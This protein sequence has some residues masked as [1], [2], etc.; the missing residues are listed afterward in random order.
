M[1][2]SSDSP[3]SDAAASDSSP[4]TQAIEEHGRL[5]R[6][7]SKLLG[8]AFYLESDEISFLTSAETVAVSMRRAKEELKTINIRASWFLPLCHWLAQRVN[9]LVDEYPSKSW[10]VDPAQ[11]E[12]DCEVATRFGSEVAVFH[13]RAKQGMANRSTLLLSNLR[14]S[15]LAGYTERLG[16]S[17]SSGMV[18]EQLLSHDHGL[19]VVA[20]PDSEQV[21]KNLACMLT[22]TGFAFAGDVSDPGLR[23]DLARYSQSEILLLSTKAE[24]ATDAIMKLR[25]FGID[26]QKTSVSGA[27][28]QS[29]VRRT[30]AACSRK[31]PVDRALSERVPAALRPASWDSYVVGRGCERCGQHGQHGVI[32]IQ[33]L[34]NVNL[35]L[36]ELIKAG[37]DQASLLKAAYPLGTRSL[38]EDGL[39]KVGSG[40]VTLQALFNAVHGVA[41]VYTDLWNLLQQSRSGA[42]NRPEAGASNEADEPLF[43]KSPRK[44]SGKPLVLVVEDDADQRSILDMVF[45]ASNYEVMSA[46]NG[47][48]ALALLTSTIPDLII[49]DLMMPEMDGAELVTAIRGNKRLSN[50]PILILTVVSDGDKEYS[51]LDLGADDYVEKTVQRK[52]LLKR[53]ERLLKRGSPP[54]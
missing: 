36:A 43:G 20:A 15:P 14:R 7:F 47:K 1:S 28:C 40:Q 45:R 53:A 17:G 44:P 13:A 18:F 22:L 31:A 54:I 4:L 46:E 48:Q 42:L 33:S 21:A 26:L 9:V 49:S 2:N 25:E 8:E 19:L 23:A 12:L 29:I 5:S 16:M 41:T 6:F 52:I 37:C 34:L 38:M 50:I 3:D 27:I 39:V 10:V 24:D 30:C 51:L 32:G 35:E 11:G